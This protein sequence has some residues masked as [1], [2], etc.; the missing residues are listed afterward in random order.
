MD[1]CG[2]QSYDGAVNMPGRYAGALTL[3]QHQ[4]AKIILFLDK[5]I[6]V[7]TSH[8]NSWI[9]PW[10]RYNTLGEQGSA[11]PDLREG[12]TAEATTAEEQANFCQAFQCVGSYHPFYPLLHP[13]MLPLYVLKTKQCQRH[14]QRCLVKRTWR[15]PCMNYTKSLKQLFMSSR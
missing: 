2:G 9:H 7:E 10:K 6:L 5:F 13:I 3:I 11:T 14:Q 12:A 1:N 15:T 8:T 4:F